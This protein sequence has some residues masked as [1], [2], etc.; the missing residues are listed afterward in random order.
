MMYFRINFPGVWTVIALVFFSIAAEATL[1]QIPRTM[2]VFHPPKALK[3]LSFP[4][5]DTESLPERF[6]WREFGPE[7]PV[8][9]QG[10]CACCWAFALTGIAE[11]LIAA[12]EGVVVDISEQWLLDCNG[13]GWD[14][15]YGWAPYELF[16]GMDA[17]G[18]TGLVLESTLPYLEAESHC[19]CDSPRTT[20]YVFAYV[21]T[22]DQRLAFTDRVNAI[23]QAIMNYGPVWATVQ[24]G[25][26]PF[27]NYSGGVFDY[28]PTE[29]DS[30]HSVMLEGWDDTLGTAGA[31]ILRNSWGDS[32]G[33][34]GYMYIA[35]DSSMVGNYIDVIRYVGS[36]TARIQ[37]M[38]E[39]QEA[40]QAG[41]QWSL[42]GGTTWIDSGAASPMIVP[43]A[44]AITYKEI[45]GFIKP[46]GEML[47]ASAEETTVHRA[48]YIAIVA[49][50]GE[51]TEGE[52]ETVEGEGEPASPDEISGRCC[53]NGCTPR[54]ELEKCISDWLLAGLSMLLLVTMA[55][56]R[57]VS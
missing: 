20:Q 31:W 24:A 51:S 46:A 18:Q 44:Y 15:D 7:I 36:K 6:D 43:G 57:K 17:C 28:Q 52:G 22:I 21:G 4:K 13:K 9:D 11:R 33:D 54:D 8:R 2:A 14:C 5:V 29:G 50:E 40:V 12:N 38:I 26:L 45:S 48:T 35:Y 39:P 16:T 41:A 19:D 10:A 32:W 34:N 1:S 25:T 27:F 37:I 47:N 55:N 30:D 56:R 53:R 49:E 23:K 42:D 3:I